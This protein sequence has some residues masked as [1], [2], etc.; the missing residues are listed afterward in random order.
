MFPKTLLCGFIGFTLFSFLMCVPLMSMQDADSLTPAE[1]LLKKEFMKKIEERDLAGVKDLVQSGKIDAKM[2]FAGYDQAEQ[3]KA[4]TESKRDKET[5]ERSK[6]WLDLNN[7]REQYE[8]ISDYLNSIGKNTLNEY[9]RKASA[10]AGSVSSAESSMSCLAS[11]AFAPVVSS[12]EIATKPLADII[13]EVVYGRP[14]SAEVSMSQATSA[15]ASSD[16]S[17]SDATESASSSYS[18]EPATLTTEESERLAQQL[19]ALSTQSASTV[20]KSSLSPILEEQGS[21]ESGASTMATSLDPHEQARCCNC[22]YTFLWALW[23][24]MT[25]ACHKEKSI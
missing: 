1:K 12:N 3:L 21:R 4:E 6:E 18:S 11:S 13:N 5:V 19:A 10:L 7:Q 25:V 15:S 24:Y 20:S 9:K 17:P 23:Y 22:F 8:S 16:Q 14:V 2:L